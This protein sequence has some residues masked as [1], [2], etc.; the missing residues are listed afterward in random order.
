MYCDAACGQFRVSPYAQARLA[1]SPGKRPTPGAARQR[2]PQH[3]HR[4]CTGSML[5]HTSHPQR[6]AQP[7]GK[8]PSCRAGRQ[9]PISAGACGETATGRTRGSGFPAPM[10]SCKNPAADARL[11]RTVPMLPGRDLGIGA[12]I[13]AVAGAPVLEEDV[14]AGQN[15]ARPPMYERGGLARRRR[16]RSG[17]LPGFAGVARPPPVP[18]I[19]ARDRFP[20]SSHVPRVAPGWC[21]FPTVRAFLLPPRTPRKSLKSIISGFS[22]I[23][24]VSTER[25]Q[26]SA[27]DGGYPPAN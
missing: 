5:L 13:P 14:P 4:S 11:V 3:F 8:Q 23:H 26:L 16:A 12:G 2:N 15:Q 27:P 21:P 24:T 25:T 1:L 10:R 22:G 6:C 17:Q 9:Q 7:A 20:G 18:G 19:R